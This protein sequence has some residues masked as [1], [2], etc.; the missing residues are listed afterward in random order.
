M[1][2][3]RIG[4]GFHEFGDKHVTQAEFLDLG[5]RHRPFGDKADMARQFETGQLS[6]AVRDQFRLAG[7]RAVSQFDKGRRYLDIARVR[8]A[9]DLCCPSSGHLA[10][11]AA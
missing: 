2:D 1:N 9:G 6:R 10:Q 5:R 11:I 3:F 4:S 8:N 7:L